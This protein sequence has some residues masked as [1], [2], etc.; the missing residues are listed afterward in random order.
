MDDKARGSS[1]NNKVTEQWNRLKKVMSDNVPGRKMS[2]YFLH[3]LL[4]HGYLEI[5]GEDNKDN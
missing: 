4:A 1:E 5:P 3:K 2:T